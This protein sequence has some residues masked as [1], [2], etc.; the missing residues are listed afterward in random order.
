MKTA[1]V[2][3]KP[4]FSDPLRHGLRTQLDKAIALQKGTVTYWL[5]Q[6]DVFAR[7][8]DNKELAPAIEHEVREVGVTPEDVPS[9]WKR[10]DERIREEIADAKD[11]NVLDNHERRPKG[12]KTEMTPCRIEWYFDRFIARKEMRRIDMIMAIVTRAK[13]AGDPVTPKEGKR[14]LK[15]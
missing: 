15:K 1:L 5:W 4:S 10:I 13:P 14:K 11:E 9:V 3:F 2:T 7:L 8:R 12:R 6:Q